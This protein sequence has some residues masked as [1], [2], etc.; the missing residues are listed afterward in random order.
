MNLLEIIDHLNDGKKIRRESWDKINYLIEK[1]Y[2]NGSKYLSKNY[3]VRG[4][5][6][7]GTFNPSLEDILATD[8]ILFEDKGEK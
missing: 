4:K 8:W 1:T 6:C 3:I 5:S 7:N 2:A